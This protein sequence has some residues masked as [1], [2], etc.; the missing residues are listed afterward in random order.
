MPGPARVSELE[1]NTL[2]GSE[3][4]DQVLQVFHHGNVA[5]SAALIL[6]AGLKRGKSFVVGEDDLTAR[7]E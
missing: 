7:V 6:R 1:R 4:C 2:P 5:A 3:T